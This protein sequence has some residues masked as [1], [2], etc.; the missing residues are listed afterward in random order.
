MLQDMD[1]E[2]MAVGGLR[3]TVTLDRILPGE[4]TGAMSGERRSAC[5]SSGKTKELSS[6]SITDQESP[7]VNTSNLG[8]FNAP[9]A[10]PA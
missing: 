6:V 10:F 3:G 9:G 4:L 1:L 5:S 2:M 7:P 8:L